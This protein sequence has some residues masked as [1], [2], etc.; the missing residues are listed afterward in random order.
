MTNFERL[1]GQV[2]LESIISDFV[3]QMVAD[4]MIGF[5][6]RDVNPARIKRFEY[7]HAAVWLGADVTY[8]GRTLHQ[9]HQTHPIL[10]GHFNRRKTILAQVL[11]K[12]HVPEDIVSGWLAH[13]D[14][15]KAEV[16]KR[17]P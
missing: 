8:Q 9:A 5:F 3:D 12:Y 7:Q 16:M 11:K 6:F 10:I 1:G 2:V 17:R 15:L 14:S 4:P 13:T